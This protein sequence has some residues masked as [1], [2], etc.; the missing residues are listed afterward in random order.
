MENVEWNCQ[1][2]YKI[3]FLLSLIMASHPISCW[4]TFAHA[5]YISI[6]IFILFEFHFGKQLSELKS[7]LIGEHQS[8][9][10]YKTST[11]FQISAILYKFLG[12][13]QEKVGQG[14]WKIWIITSD[15]FL[16]VMQRPVL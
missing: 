6:V 5:I 10:S 12:G 9:F 13:R 16:R 3:V 2:P 7:H 4:N 8:L 1:K 11:A 14:E 15:V